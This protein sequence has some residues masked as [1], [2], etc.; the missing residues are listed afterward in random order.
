MAIHSLGS[1]SAA[2]LAFV[3]FGIGLVFCVMS[4]IK[5]NRADTLA[6]APV[7]QE[8]DVTSPSP[9]EV[10]VML[11]TPRTSQEF[12]EFQIQLIDRQSGQVGM[13]GYSYGTA[14]EA[15]YGVSTMQVPFGRMTL[16][17]GAYLMRIVGLREGSDY[18]RY[19]VILSRPYMGRMALQIIGIVFC[20]VGMLLSVIGAAWL[21]GLMT[22]RG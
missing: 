2:G 4:L 8:Q 17:A 13:F 10:V 18:S 22:Q 12:R 5:G 3:L 20:G 14:Q 16:R 11:E 21:A 15:V 7:V 9:G 6:S 19:R 1:V